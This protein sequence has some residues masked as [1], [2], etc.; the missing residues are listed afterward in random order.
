MIRVI[1]EDGIEILLN[2]NVIETV[3]DNKDRKAVIKLGTGE[4]ITARTPAYD[5]IGKI[6]AYYK[7]IKDER[8]E[9]EKA[10]EKA[11]KEKEKELAKAEKKKAGLAEVEEALQTPIDSSEG[12]MNE[13]KG[14]STTPGKE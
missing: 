11:L 7:G 13:G 9:Y 5:I 6:K 14:F 3:E 10:H 12:N 4:T 1:R 8:T 2:T